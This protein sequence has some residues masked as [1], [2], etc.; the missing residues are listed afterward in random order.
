M[1]PGQIEIVVNETVAGQNNGPGT[2][3]DYTAT[4]VGNVVTSGLNKVGDQ[5]VVLQGPGTY[6]GDV[7]IKEGALLVQNDTAL[8]TPPAVGAAG[9]TTTVEA[10]ASLLLGT[11]IP[12]LNGGRQSGV[13]VVGERLVLNGTGTKTLLRPFNGGSTLDSDYAQL[14]VGQLAPLVILANDLFVNGEGTPLEL[15]DHTPLVPALNVTPTTGLIAADYVWRGSVGLNVT[16]PIDVQAGTRLSIVGGIDDGTNA[17]P[18]GSGLIKFDTGE[19]RL[20][21]ASTYKGTTYVGTSGTVNPM[22]GGVPVNTLLGGG[23]ALPG[24]ILSVAHGQALGQGTNTAANGTIVQ[25]GSAIQLEGNITVSGEQLTIAG[26]GVTSSAISSDPAVAGWHQVGPAP[27][28]NG[29]TL[30]TS[31]TTTAGRINGIAIDPNDPLTMFVSTAGGGWKTV[32]GGKSWAPMFDS[33]FDQPIFTGAI[34]R[35]LTDA[36]HIYLS[37]GEVNDT[38]DSFAGNGIYESFDSGRTWSVIGNADVLFAGLSISK[39]VVDPLTPGILYAATSDTQLN[40]AINTGRVGVWRWDGSLWTNLTAQVST[41]RNLV[42]TPGPEDD[43]SIAFPQNNATWS[44]IAVTI[45]A[46]RLNP[47]QNNAFITRHTVLYAALGTAGGDNPLLAPPNPFVR[48]GSGANKVVNAVY[49]LDN[50]TAAVGSALRWYVGGGFFDFSSGV[51]TAAGARSDTFASSVN[52]AQYFIG[53]IKLDVAFTASN[54]PNA[55]GDTGEHSTIHVFASVSESAMEDGSHQ[56]GP[57]QNILAVYYRAPHTQN[58]ADTWARVNLPV[59]VFGNAGHYA[60]ALKIM[61][62]NNAPVVFIGGRNGVFRSNDLG[63]TWLD[64][65]INANLISVPYS[66]QTMTESAGQLLAGTDGGLFSYNPTTNAWTSLNGNMGNSLVN[67]LAVNSNDFTSITAGTQSGGIVQSTSGSLVWNRVDPR[68]NRPYGGQV[69]IDPTNPQV[70]Y[71]FTAA[72]P[73]EAMGYDVDERYNGVNGGELRKF[74]PVTGSWVTLNLPFPNTGDGTPL[75]R[76]AVNPALRLDPNNPNRIV[77]VYEILQAQDSTPGVGNGDLRTTRLYESLDGGATFTLLHSNTQSSSF[78]LPNPV[79]NELVPG[80]GVSLSLGGFQ[81]DFAFDAAFPLVT[82][83]G[84]N[85]NDNQTFAYTNGVDIF[86]TKNRG[87]TWVNRNTLPGITAAMTNITDPVR[88]FPNSAGNGTAGANTRLVANNTSNIADVV[89]DPSDRDTMYAIRNST[90][91]LPV[92]FKTTD[93][94]QTWLDWSG[95]LSSALPANMAAWK[96][97]ID[98]RDGSLYLA[99][100]KGV[101]YA[102][103]G[104]TQWQEMALGLPNVPVHDLVL[105][106][107]TNTLTAGTYGRGVYQTWLNKESDHVGA[108]RAVAGSAVWTGDVVLTGDTTFTADGSQKL[109]GLTNVQLNIGGAIKDAAGSGAHTITVGTAANAGQDGSVIFSGVNTYAGQTIVKEGALVANNLS[110]LGSP[111]AN[112]VVET[113]AVLELNSSVNAEPLELHGDGSSFGFNGHRTGSLRSIANSN[114]YTGPITLATDVTIGVDSGSTLTVTGKIGE[115][116]GAPFDLTKELTGTLVLAAANDYTGVTSI[117]QGTLRAANDMALGTATGVADGTKVLDGAVLQV[118]SNSATPLTIA[119]HLSLSGTGSN[120]NGALFNTVGTNTLTG[121]VVLDVNPGFFPTPNPSGVVNI[122][123]ASGTRLTINGVVSDRVSSEFP[124]SEVVPSGLTKVGS[125]TL[126][127][128]GANTYSGT[129]TIA[130]GGGILEVQNDKALGSS[131]QNEIQRIIVSAPNP[132]GDDGFTITFNPNTTFAE[133][134]GFIAYGAPASAVQGALVSLNAIFAG[135]VLVTRDTVSVATTAGPRLTYV[136]TVKFLGSF[137][138]VPVALMSAVGQGGT[139]ATTAA[140]A[141]TNI[142]TLVNNGTTLQ[143]NKAT[144]VTVTD[145]A[146][147]LN[148][149]GVGGIG[150]LNNVAGDNTWTGTVLP[151]PDL[152]NPNPA[153][154]PITLAATSSI[155]VAGGSLTVSSGVSGV[156]ASTLIKVGAGTL[157]FPT[158]NTYQGTTEIRAGVLNISDTD[159]LGTATT[160]EVQQI[161]LTGARTGSFS[162]TFTPPGSAVSETTAPLVI[163]SADASPDRLAS[164][165]QAALEALPSINPGEVSVVRVGTTNDVYKITFLGIRYG[166][167]DIPMLQRGSTTSTSTGLAIAESLRGGLGATVVSPP[168]AGVPSTSTDAQKVSLGGPRTGNFSLTFLPPGSVTPETTATLVINSGDT[169]PDRLAG[170]IKLALEALPSINPGDVTVTQVTPGSDDYLIKFTGQYAGRDIPLMTAGPKSAATTIAITTVTEGGVGATL[171]LDGDQVFSQE[172]VTLYGNGSNNSGAMDSLTGINTWTGPITLGS[173]ASVG[174]QDQATLILATGIGEA[175]PGFGLTKFGLGTVQMTGP[176]ANTYTGATR[177]ASGVLQL[178]KTAGVNSVAGN[179]LF[180]GDTVG[181]DE[182]AVVQLL[183]NE[184]IANGVNVIV[185]SDGLFD[186]NDRTETVNGLTI[187]SGSVRAGADSG[188]DGQLTVASL[189]MIGGLLDTGNAADGVT[190][191]GTG[192]VAGA[193]DAAGPATIQGAGLLDLDGTVHTFN[194]TTNGTELPA[195]VIDSRISGSAANG[196]TKVGPGTL[197]LTADN[198]STLTGPTAV[199]AG[200]LQVDGMVNTVTLSG[201]GTVSGVGTVGRINVGTAAAP[202]PNGTIAPGDNLTF[203]PE[204]RLTVNPGGAMTWNSGTSF[205]VNLT[206]ATLGAGNQGGYDQLVVSSGSLSLNGAKLV[207]LVGPVIGLGDEFTIIQMTNGAILA[208]TKFAPVLDAAGNPIADPDLV[209]VNGAKFRVIY[210]VGANGSVVLRREINTTTTDLTTSG[211]PTAYGQTGGFQFIAKVTGEPGAGSPPTSTTVSLVVTNASGAAVYTNTIS[212]DATGKA[213][214]DPQAELGL[215][216]PVDTYTAVATFNGTDTFNMSSDSAVQVVKKGDTTFTL[217]GTPDGGTA[218]TG[219]V[220]L[221]TGQSMDVTVRVSPKAPAGALGGSLRPSGDVSFRVDNGTPIAATLDANGEVTI[222]VSALALGTHTVDVIYGGDTDYNG[223]QSTSTTR[224]QVTVKKGT[225]AMD[226][227]LS[228]SNVVVGDPVT[229]T[230]T[231]NPVGPATLPPSGTVAF[232]RGTQATGL[233]LGSGTISSSGVA[234]FS[235]PTNLL[236]VGSYVITAV[237]AGDGNYAAPTAVSKTLTVTKAGTTTDLVSSVNPSTPSQPVTFTATVTRNSGTGTPTGSV[238]FSRDGAILATVAVNATTGR[239]VF[240]TSFLAGVYNVKAAYLGS[241]AL[242]TSSKTI[243]QRVGNASRTVLTSSSPVA[244]PGDPVTFTATVSRGPGVLATQPFPMGKVDFFDDSVSTT[245]P[246]FT[247]PVS[248]TGV[249]TWTPSPTLTT[250]IH[251]IR[252]VFTPTNAYIGSSATLSQS[253]VFGSTTSVV[254]TSGSVVTGESAHFVAHVAGGAGGSGVPT[255]TVQFFANGVS[256]GTATLDGSGDATIDTTGLNATNTSVVAKYLGDTQ[257]GPSQGTTNVD[258]NPANSDTVLGSSGDTTGFGQLATFTATVS[259]QAP[260]GGQP[261]GTVKFTATPTAGGTP[262]VS[263]ALPINATTGAAT[264][265]I[266]T[267]PRGS[268]TVTAHYTPATVGGVASY[269]SSDS[270]PLSHRVLNAAATTI[271]SSASVALP[272]SPITLTATVRPAVGTPAGSGTPTGNVVFVIDG[273]DFG[274]GSLTF[275]SSGVGTATLT[276]PAGSLTLGTHTVVARYEPDP[277]NGYGQGN[278]PTLIQGV[279]GNTSTSLST[280]NASV[281]V[282][283]PV[284]FTATVDQVA[285]PAGSALPTGMVQFFANGVSIGTATVTDVGGVATA[286]LTTSSLKAGTPTITAKY[287]GDTKNNASPASAGLTQE[288]VPA[289]SSITA[290]PTTLTPAVNALVAVTIRAISPSGGV[291]TNYTGTVRTVLGAHVV[292]GYMYGGGTVSFVN[293]VATFSNLRFSRIGKYTVIFVT[294][295]GLRTAL[296]FSVVGGGR[297]S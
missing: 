44:D 174:A 281:P 50:P 217:S 159:A 56:S 55:R 181:G 206:D 91:G 34:A 95:S 145:E 175:A 12:D 87:T 259:A 194:V 253:I 294:A 232:Y 152:Q 102:A 49:K 126:A 121:N 220:T 229:F 76:L 85:T 238:Q 39:L 284:T 144:N 65:G 132:D 255:G 93:A 176:L 204:G 64:V 79:L 163:N 4:L 14:P 21:G 224:L 190:I 1:D 75:N 47:A 218:S 209:F 171:Q 59:G 63:T 195:M 278:S 139:I 198:T 258:V 86:I 69:L 179:R 150:A 246:R 241:A 6:Q 272:T 290:T 182:S 260:G 122:G 13:Q 24:G 125:G 70:L 120:G 292:G 268:Y 27:V 296:T 155:G 22:V 242:D 234:T 205:L 192:T 105:N 147:T 237:Y 202:T 136:Y 135:D 106:L 273:A 141:D 115:G 291:A 111:G 80:R 257:Y 193:A 283:T 103:D 119:E 146:L 263:A 197:A 211:S 9:T 267:L 270:N 235:P 41:G 269:I 180:V 74:D 191:A 96:L 288:V 186:A 31:P 279:K 262:I 165:I 228:S 97:V 10:G 221:V 17:A 134:T 62:I 196:L 266:S 92:I 98:P 88:T 104:G 170:A 37:T 51:G 271:A 168:V 286:K 137:A 216:F 256:L 287:L 109:K 223:V 199:T 277:G 28:N 38:T 82:D 40:G 289:A 189:T 280:S 265:N 140:V 58:A 239:A 78:A 276:V 108:F 48:P 142:G 215:V 99:G 226:L 52:N 244:S 153:S 230:A 162:L 177:A 83:K 156:A 5:L 251:P 110:A 151:G 213:V 282:G 2:T 227:T 127:L 184:Q 138:N 166:G 249:F 275:N 116:A 7:D 158:A 173:D 157:F 46:E 3:W 133:T 90:D 57:T 164:A 67:G 250:G 42:G 45:V 15:Y 161:T 23:S 212:L 19:L 148:G 207:G 32:D 297:Q 84:A 117:N 219:P 274:T 254:F 222:P 128:G 53:N 123:V 66:V 183:S 72:G 89:I 248:G 101:F 178:N 264:W 113:G 77:V 107:A 61:I 208:S 261:T 201:T 203:S 236:P 118:G 29:P 129:T 26:S 172:A 11:T 8:G 54:L 25:A 233:F 169:I 16:S 124:G 68:T 18:E 293:G 131:N 149:Q 30:G 185:E 231:L 20:A 214:F 252:A 200:V 187:N 160:N 73:A 188:R 36:N 143:L 167:R 210:T 35:H 245:T 94:G 240:T 100:D 112:T 130:L 33:Q 285:V 247:T 60:N 114:T 43:D 243:T 225:V 295:D 154:T 81:G 71:A